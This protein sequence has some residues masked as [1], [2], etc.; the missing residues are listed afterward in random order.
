MR[1][2]R[3]STVELVK[4]CPQQHEPLAQLRPGSSRD[5]NDNPLSFELLI[6]GGP[7]H[8]LFQLPN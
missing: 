3:M 5:L 6:A 7:T 1:H 8:L 2:G 4:R